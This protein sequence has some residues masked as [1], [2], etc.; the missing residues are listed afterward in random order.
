MQGQTL[1]AAKSLLAS[2]QKTIEGKNSNPAKS[3]YAPVKNKQ[4][5]TVQ[6]VK[7]NQVNDSLQVYGLICSKVIIGEGKPIKTSSNIKTALRSNLPVGRFREFGLK[8][9]KVAK[10]DGDTL[11]LE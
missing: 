7:L 1:D 6:G 10:I 4:G 5:E 3:A 9:I 8:N 11:I 2:F